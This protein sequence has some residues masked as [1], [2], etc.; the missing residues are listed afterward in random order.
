MRLALGNSGT[1]MSDV[2][3]IVIPPEIRRRKTDA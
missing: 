1:T 2:Y 3:K